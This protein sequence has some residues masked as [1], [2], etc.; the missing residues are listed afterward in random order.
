[1][2]AKAGNSPSLS[3][4][5]FHISGVKR[6]CSL[7]NCEGTTI[8]SCNILSHYNRP[9]DNHEECRMALA[10]V[11][12]A[13]P[14]GDSRGESLTIPI[15]RLLYAKAKNQARRQKRSAMDGKVKAKHS[16][17]RHGMI[18]RRLKFVRVIASR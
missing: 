13:K 7:T 10:P 9:G 11:N 17:K 16:G 14:S 2:C 8:I 1:V 18:K 12:D 4:T 6:R 3:S 15:A 5:S